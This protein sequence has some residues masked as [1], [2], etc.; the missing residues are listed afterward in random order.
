MRQLLI[1]LVLIALALPSCSSEL[2]AGSLRLVAQ[3]H[4]DCALP[5]GSGN[6]PAGDTDEDG[7]CDDEDTCPEIA[8]DQSLDE[9]GDGVGDRCDPCFGDGALGDADDDDFCADQDCDDRDKDTYP[10]AEEICDGR[11]ND[12]GGVLAE[13]EQDTDGDGVPEC[14]DRCL[15]G[16]GFGDSD[17]D[18]ICSDIDLCEGDND[19]ADVD[20]DGVCGDRDACLGDDDEGDADGD[21]V[22]DDRDVCD[23]DD[24]IGD[25]DEDGFCADLDCDDEQQRVYPG[26]DETCDGVDESCDGARD[27]GALCPLDQACAA[28]SCT[29]LTP[30]FEDRDGDSFGD[31]ERVTL[32]APGTLCQ[33]LGLVGDGSDCDDDPTTCGADCAPD[34]MERCDALDRD[35]T[36]RPDNEPDALCDDPGFG[37]AVCRD[38]A[39]SVA[40]DDGFQLSDTACVDIEECD[41]LPCVEPAECV[42]QVGSYYCE[43]PVGSVARDGDV[44]RCEAVCG[45]AIVF[46]EEACDDGNDAPED[47]C[48]ACEIELGWECEPDGCASVCGDGLIRGAE[49]CDDANR[50]SDD[51]CEAC[52]IIAPYT[53]LGQPSDCQLPAVCANGRLEA[54]E[55]CDDGNERAGDGCSASCFVEAG[56]QCSAEPDRRSLCQ[57]F[58]GPD[59]AE[60]ET[61]SAGNSGQ[62]ARSGDTSGC[63]SS[64]MGLSG[65]WLALALLLSSVSLGRRRAASDLRLTSARVGD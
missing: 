3:A 56:W 65:G 57:D 58:G 37:V 39:C 23:G 14:R 4:R 34:A 50:L 8:N 31:A 15:G 18:G 12:C 6:P 26:A 43:C 40:C 19:T 22:C 33:E 2:E 32:H 28:G 11:L 49:R 9:D 51:G 35:C 52:A 46:G 30:C 16:D 45:D 42:N 48:D 38:A 64:A 55:T 27:E 44:E 53:C 1:S 29:S 62:V 25:L 47:G 21:G 5:D 10:G 36:G 59:I 41:G 60:S 63:S 7:F 61:S 17:G 13:D 54:G 24:A 20:E